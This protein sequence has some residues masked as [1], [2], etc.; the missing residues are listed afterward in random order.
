[1]SSSNQSLRFN[2]HKLRWSLVDFDSLT[3]MLLVLEFG[4]EKYAPNNWRKGLHREE[5]LESVQRHLIELFENKEMDG[6]SKL[7][8]MGHIMCNAMFYLHHAKN[9]TFSKE[10][11]NPFNKKG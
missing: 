2:Q 6:E 5:I 10:R 3:E 4:A 1:M 7:H 9:G 11:A 8:H